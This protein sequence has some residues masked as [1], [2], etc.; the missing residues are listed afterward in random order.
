[1]I[2]NI[3][4]CLA[5]ILYKAVIISSAAT[6]V[7]GENE[8]IF[9][10][11]ENN[12]EIRGSG[13]SIMVVCGRHL[14]LTTGVV[15]FMPGLESSYVSVRLCTLLPIVVETVIILAL[16]GLIFSQTYY[17]QRRV[18]SFVTFGVIVNCENDIIVLNETS[19]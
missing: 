16:T 19:L 10:I 11:Y 14:T 17:V 5:Y 8:I 18:R 12:V 6:G 13:Y 1:M 9:I 2:Y 4:G 3:I 15:E 7:Q